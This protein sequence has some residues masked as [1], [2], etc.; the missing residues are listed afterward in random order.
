MDEP[1]ALTLTGLMKRLDAG[2]ISSEQVTKAYLKRIEALNPT[3]NAYVTVD[4]Q[5]AVEQA[6]NADRLRADG[7]KA[8]LLGA[9]VAI[10]DAIVTKGLRTTCSSRI[11][12]NFI[13]PYDAFVIR[14]F[15]V[16][17]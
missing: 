2:D 15:R 1:C 9:P 7:H 6:R 13:P 14:K 17:G 4:A 11:L 16:T 8:P 10:K 12:E 3:L 5:G